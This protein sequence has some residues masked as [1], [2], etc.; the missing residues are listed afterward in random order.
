MKPTPSILDALELDALPA[1][2]QQEVLLTLNDLIFRGSL[3]RL[4]ERMD[5]DQHDAFSALL[6]R[7]APE[8]ELNDFLKNIPG[9]ED[10]V[11]E[12]V[13]ELTSDILSVIK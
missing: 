6:S 3:V 5:A 9:S 7:D 12:T 10:V 11:K 13:D 8:E 4:I 2:E 1:A